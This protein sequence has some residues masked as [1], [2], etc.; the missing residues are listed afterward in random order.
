[1]APQFFFGPDSKA[2]GDSL[3]FILFGL[4]SFMGWPFEGNQSD[5]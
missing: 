1:M 4:T 3:E 5:I 2:E